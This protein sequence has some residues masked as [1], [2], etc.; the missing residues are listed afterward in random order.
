MKYLFLF[1]GMI[2][3]LNVFAQLPDHRETHQ[4]PQH[5]KE[6]RKHQHH[7][8]VPAVSGWVHIKELDTETIYYMQPTEVT[9]LDW[10]YFMLDRLKI[11]GIANAT[12]QFV[13][14]EKNELNNRFL[15]NTPELAALWDASVSSESL[16]TTVIKNALTKKGVDKLPITGISPEAAKKYMEYVA[17]TYKST[18][19][20]GI[21]NA[22]DPKYKLEE[23]QMIVRFPTH[24]E[25]RILLADFKK[26]GADSTKLKVQLHR[27]YDDKF[28]PLFNATLSDSVLTNGCASTQA[29]SE[30]ITKYGKPGK[31]VYPVGSYPVDAH[32]LYDL[33][34]NV[35]EMTTEENLAMGG[36]YRTPASSC[37]PESGQAYAKASTWLG[38]RCVVLLKKR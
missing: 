1:V 23:Y 36:G 38:F 6:A 20:N 37:Q 34:G 17:V 10:C 7:E 18:G 5:H 32:G 2:V 9:I 35:A 21:H 13:V 12:Y 3:S 11:E 29:G 25:Y 27:G 22:F 31:I 26:A 33:R 28:C 8:H 16:T 24:E 19:A 14:P 4:K 30:L 15:Y